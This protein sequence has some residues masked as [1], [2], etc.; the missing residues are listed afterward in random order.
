MRQKG[1]IEK[2]DDFNVRITQAQVEIMKHIRDGD[3]YLNAKLHPAAAREFERAES[4]IHAVPYEIKSL[5]ELL[6]GIA[7]SRQKAEAGLS[8]TSAAADKH[9][10]LAERY[11]QAGDV[12]KAQSECGRAIQADPIHLA[13][14]ALL[15][16]LSF[17]LGKMAV[18]PQ[19]AQAAAVR[20]EQVI[21]ES[22]QALARARQHFAHRRPGEAER[23]CLKVLEYAKW[24]P[25]DPEMQAR[26]EA[27]L[28]ELKR[29]SR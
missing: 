4:K 25:K 20:R 18:D 8:G 16:E 28:E 29:I 22:D 11:F 9:Y 3:R 14:R 6:P 12:E 5:T 21:V 13:T 2:S 26:R 27:A 17:I 7:Q 23:E 24:L 19:L 10:R 1:L 15:T